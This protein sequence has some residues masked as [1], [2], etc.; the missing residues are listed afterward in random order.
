MKRS[1]IKKSGPVAKKWSAFRKQWLEDNPPPYIC[2]VCFR[3]IDPEYVV[4]DHILPRAHRPDLRFEPSNIQPAHYGCN[5]AKGGS[6]E[7]TQAEQDP[8]S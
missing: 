6:H 7:R 5:Q 4:L 2:G 1:W 3:P 8:S